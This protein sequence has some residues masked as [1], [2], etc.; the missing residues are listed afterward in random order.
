MLKCMHNKK[1]RKKEV[2]KMNTYQVLMMENKEFPLGGKDDSGNNVIVTHG[3]NDNGQ[4]VKVQTVQKNGWIRTNYYYENGD[5]E[6][7]FSK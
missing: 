3:E 5:F 2:T 1:Q 4:Y 7:L 6:E